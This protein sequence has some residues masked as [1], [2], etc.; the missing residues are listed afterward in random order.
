MLSALA[1]LAAVTF[2]P[3]DQIRV[4][5]TKLYQGAVPLDG[6]CEIFVHVNVVDFGYS[7]S[8]GPPIACEAKC[9]GLVHLLHKSCDFSCDSVCEFTHSVEVDYYQWN[10]SSWELINALSTFG[11]ALSETEVTAL[12][13]NQSGETIL[14]NREALKLTVNSEHFNTLPCGTTSKFIYGHD[15]KVQVDWRLR[16]V[17]MIDGKPV[18]TQGPSGFS[19]IAALRIPQRGLRSD[20]WRIQCACNLVE[21]HAYGG[22]IETGTELA[23]TV[24]PGDPFAD[25]PAVPDTF[26]P[27]HVT[28]SD[29]ML[30]PA[31]GT[32]QLEFGAV[33]EDMNSGVLVCN[34]PFSAPFNVTLNP[35][36]TLDTD[37][38]SVQDVVISRK[39]ECT[40]AATG[41]T[42][43]RGPSVWDQNAQAGFRLLCLEMNKRE[44]DPKIKYRVL[45]FSDPVLSRLVQ[46]PAPRFGG[47]LPQARVWVYTDGGTFDQISKK[48]MFPKLQLKDYLI[49]VHDAYISGANLS[50]KKYSGCFEPATLAGIAD[51]RSALKWYAGELIRRDSKKLLQWTQKKDIFAES[52]AA[53]TKGETYAHIARLTSILASSDSADAQNSALA[54]LKNMSDSAREKLAKEELGASYAL[55]LSRHPQVAKLAQDVSKTYR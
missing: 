23:G 50:G 48:L 52:I 25:A 16:R 41:E 19:A 47:A 53:D 31:G 26:A 39:Y 20:S 8:M 35:G 55:V 18:Y 28:P 6:N 46:L 12:I 49:A 43:R 37:A 36:C 32:N 51:R 9:K 54:I 17:T 40:I 24:I 15:F 34:N 44:P 38:D 29:P 27:V 3:Q 11:S 1:L 33:C 2:A 22:P 7:G 10:M 21:E 30:F 4:P 45:R 14:P 42:V 5:E 13:L